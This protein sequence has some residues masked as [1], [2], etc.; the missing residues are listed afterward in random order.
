MYTSTDIKSIAR[1]SAW[2]RRRLRKTSEYSFRDRWRVDGAIQDVADLFLNTAEIADWWPQFSC[3][4][5]AEAGSPD[6][7]TRSFG[8]RANGFLPYAL[9]LDFRVTRVQFPQQFSVEVS[10][11]LRGHGGGKLR[12]TGRHVEID[13]DLT[14]CA[15][16]PLLHVLSLV[17]RPALVAQHRWVMRQGERGLQNVLANRQSMGAP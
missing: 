3:V 15:V 12:Q 5:I 17:A 8:A 7:A 13:F 1:R 11:D 4:A 16:R 6:G 2:V 9:V 10:G 14:I